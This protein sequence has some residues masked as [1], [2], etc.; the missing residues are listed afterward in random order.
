M[1]RD[2]TPQPLS[3]KERVSQRRD[4]AWRYIGWRMVPPLLVGEGVS[5]ALASPPEARAGSPRPPGRARLR[6]RRLPR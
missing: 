3:H 4:V 2:L 6:A 5:G 1:A